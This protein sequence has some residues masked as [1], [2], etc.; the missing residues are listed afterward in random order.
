M[1]D[2]PTHEVSSGHSVGGRLLPTIKRTLGWVRHRL[3]HRED[4]EHVQ[5]R[6]RIIFALL[7]ALYI[8]VMAKNEAMLDQGLA[9]AGV[10]LVL[11][12][13]LFAHILFRPAISPARR[14]CGM[15]I[16]TFGLN[17]L[18]YIGGMSASVFYPIL[19][20]II[21]GHGFR[22]GKPYLFAAA[23]TSLLLFAGV[24]IFNNEWR[25]LPELDFA[26][27]LALVVLPAYFSSLLTTLNKA[28]DT[29][30]A[31]T[32]AKSQFIANMSHEFRTPLNAIIGMT[33]LLRAG[34]LD[35]SQREMAVT[36]RAS[37]DNLLGLVNDILDI[38]RIES[39]T[40]TIESVPFNLH[41]FCAQLQS[42]LLPSAREKGIYL[43]LRID[44]SLPIHLTGAT[45]PLTQVLTNLISNAIKFTKAGGVLVN[46][47]CC[48]DE[49]DRTMVRFDVSDTGIGISV[50]AQGH[51]FERFRQA[52]DTTNQAFGGTG[53][54]L[55]I[56]RELVEMMGG[57]MGVSSSPGQGSTFWFELPFEMNEGTRSVASAS[58]QVIVLA[59]DQ[60]NN[61]IC[62]RLTRL[63][64]QNLTARHARE[65][66]P[67]LQ[68]AT[69]RSAILLGNAL[70]PEELELVLEAMESGANIINMVSLMP[71]KANMTMQTMA[72]LA[73]DCD[74]HE[75]RVALNAALVT[76][77]QADP[78]SIK[79]AMH[80]NI[81]SLVL[82]A[83]DNRVNQKVISRILEYAGH[84]V[85]LVS[86]GE[87]AVEAVEKNR[88][89]IALIDLN[90]PGMGGIEAVKLMRFALDLPDL[91]ILVAITA[92]ATSE[93]RE[94]AL[95]TGFGEVLTKPIDGP[96]LIKAIDRIMTTLAK[97]EQRDANAILHPMQ[98]QSGSPDIDRPVIL[99]ESKL[100]NL[101]KL[102][103][104][105]GFLEDVIGEFVEDCDQLIRN[106]RE[107]GANKDVRSFRDTAHA[108]RSSAA[109]MG[110]T[111]MFELCLSWREID[112]HALMM[113][114]LTEVE[115]LR[116][117]FV[118]LRAMLRTYLDN[119]KR[120]A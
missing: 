103:S 91:P 52:D 16:D 47:R 36:M 21:L 27:M 99:D 30:E 77:D 116:V 65:I 97:P 81:P 13:L 66:E 58:G 119:Y 106:L 1:A 40:L 84:T 120:Q 2:R 19:L 104:G 95:Q 15:L 69:L 111:S 38:E 87:E 72:D 42:I 74:D 90:M 61:E 33:D 98:D 100:D 51:I 85:A 22:F 71:S 6:I 67:I 70:P 10:S 37:A 113:R 48:K 73:D 86:N 29:A 26:L 115:K 45:K 18:M 8:F 63:G 17:G 28:R 117:Q 34:E 9:I 118:S 39:H 92:D 94:L 32:K 82:L 56:S 14:I 20:W 50:D 89:D 109:H 31:A 53:L 114:S 55:A 35:H 76:G 105:D 64:V 107:A 12:T 4:S 79:T 7:I 78:G 41:V 80:A 44:P 101:A 112:D 3:E 59:K 49:F 83:E 54:G 11:S 96:K 93:T 88:Y 24:I 46:V 108:L 25:S 5:A 23:S 75:L 110:A 102:D 62:A 68:R 43:R 60:R 57:F